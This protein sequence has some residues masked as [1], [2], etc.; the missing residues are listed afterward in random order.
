MHLGLPG[1]LCLLAEWGF[2][3]VQIIFAGYIGLNE[4]AAATCLLNLDSMVAVSNLGFV[5]TLS[6]KQGN[7]LGA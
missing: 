6:M 3:E 2:F 7:L 1:I 4:L 5:R